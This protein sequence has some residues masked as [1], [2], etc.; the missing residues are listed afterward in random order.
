MKKIYSFLFITAMVAF[1]FQQVEAQET[2]FGAK[3]GISL[4]SLTTS[5]SGGGM[6]VS[7]TSDMKLGFAVG[8]YAIIPF[9]DSFAFQPELMFVQKGGEESNGGDVEVTLNYLD[10]PL[11]ARYTLPLDGN[12]VPYLNAGPVIGISLGGTESFDG[13]SED[14]EDLN[15]VVFGVAIGGG[16]GFGQ[17]HVDLRY[18]FGVTDII[19]TEDFGIDLSSTTSGLLFTVGYTF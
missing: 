1:S 18:E 2:R 4:Y 17:F 10:I 14:I 19:E 12:V 9:S 15:G 13:D 11:L 3:A 8:A 6:S 5:A 16:V 7:E